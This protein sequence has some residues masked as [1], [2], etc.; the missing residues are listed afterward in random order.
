MNP[1]L[2]HFYELTYHAD[3]GGHT[4]R[5]AEGDIYRPGV[6]LDSCRRWRT[7]LAEPVVMLAQ[8]LDE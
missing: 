2:S 8:L 5:E 1:T 3:R 6:Y 4:V 7:C